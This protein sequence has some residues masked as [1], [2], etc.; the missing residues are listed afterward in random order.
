MAADQC[1]ELVLEICERLRHQGTGG[2]D[3]SFMAAFVMLMKLALLALECK[4]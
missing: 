3:F 4:R 1:A 2:Q